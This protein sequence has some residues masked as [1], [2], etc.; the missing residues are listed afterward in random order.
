MSFKRIKNF[1][2]LLIATIIVCIL[3][4]CTSNNRQKE[5]I[6]DLEINTLYCY[7]YNYDPNTDYE[8]ELE[9]IIFYKDFSLFLCVIEVSN[10]NGKTELKSIKSYTEYT[11][12]F[13]DNL[14]TFNMNGMH[15]QTATI[16]VNNNY[17][18]FDY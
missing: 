12:Q 17:L 5:S 13:Y 18:L 10:K 9:G 15:E 4:S 7:G 6:G 8:G 14:I 3:C 2:F 16:Q 1:S 11:Y